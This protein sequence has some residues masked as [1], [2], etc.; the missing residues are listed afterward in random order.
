MNNKFTQFAA[1][2]LRNQKDG[3]EY[4][5]AAANGERNKVKLLVELENGE[6]VPVNNFVMF[7]NQRKTKENHPDVQFYFSNE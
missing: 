2:W 7:F 5:S 1:G 4:V 6:Q 3:T